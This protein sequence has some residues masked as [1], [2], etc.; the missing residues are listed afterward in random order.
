MCFVLCPLGEANLNVHMNQ[1]YGSLSEGSNSISPGQGWDSA[2]LTSSQELLIRTV[3]GVARLNADI[4]TH[5]LD[6]FRQRC[7]KLVSL[8]FYWL[9]SWKTYTATLCVSLIWVIYVERKVFSSF[10][11]RRCI[12]AVQ[13][14]GGQ[15][16]SILGNGQCNYNGCGFLVRVLIR[17]PRPNGDTAGKTAGSKPWGKWLQA[18][19][20]F[21]IFDIPYCFIETGIPKKGNI[22]MVFAMDSAFISIQ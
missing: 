1:R 16:G 15:Y 13:G 7:N 17:I 12:A 5:Y 11:G 10:T 18:C 3:T 9:A 8:C 2:L 21:P 4:L 14:K 6:S 20:L 22:T 19:Q